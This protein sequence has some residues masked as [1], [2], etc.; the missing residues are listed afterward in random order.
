LLVL[1]QQFFDFSSESFDLARAAL[2]KKILTTSGDGS[3]RAESPAPRRG[4]DMVSYPALYQINTRVW[5][6][7]L[8]DS[9]GRPAT[10]A[11]I[12]DDF[13]DR[14]AF[15]GF[16]YIWFLGL[17]QT[18]A[19]GRQ[20]ALGRPDWRQAF[21]RILPDFTET[22]VTGSPFAVVAYT[23]NRDFGD[24]T[25][26]PDLRQRLLARGLK[27]MVD[28]VPNHTALD[29]PWVK[30][31]PEFYIQGSQADLAREPSNYR[32]VETQRGAV[33]LAHG[34]DPYFP[35][36]TDTFQLN[37]RHPALREVMA[38]ELLNLTDLADGVRC[39]MAMLLLPA[40][41]R[42]TWGSRSRPA[43]GVAPVDTSFWPEAISRVKAKNSRFSFMAE[44]YWGLESELLQQGFDYA[45]D[46]GLYDLLVSRDVARVRA[47]LEADQAYQ[48]K[49]VRFLENHDE[50]RAAQKF[51]GPV[52]QAA[53]VATYFLLG[54]RFFHE[55][56][57][58]GR[59]VHVPMQL[60]RR[61]PEAVDPVWQEFY[62]KLLT[63]LKRP[64]L[65]EGRWQ[66]R[67]VH[68]AQEGSFAPDRFLAY[69]WEGAAGQH[70]L[71]TVNYGSTRGRGYV[72]LSGAD[73]GE[74]RIQLQDLMSAAVSEED[75]PEVLSRGLYLDLPAWGFQ[76][77]V[78]TEL[79]PARA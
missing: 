12:P 53:A 44:V 3:V 54:L 48:E 16:D 59:R 56:Q 19:A 11:D 6:R 10:L 47:H 63:C 75:G 22:D 49:L 55:G 28:F 77:L 26:L 67:E 18:G 29:H 1:Y 31:H 42:R 65:R 24:D 71:V 40:I 25:T 66:L 76:V 58:E 9:L 32:Q 60:G 21:Q 68:P 13:L 69:W 79:P 20:M 34:R 4:I 5:L 8:A 33:I 15:L 50:A 46:K 72:D 35:G 74:N 36:W 57:L 78:L 61:P 23:L 52:H 38:Q 64:E 7:E 73:L 70:L 43:D 41:I 27:L 45:Y 30:I 2:V 37:Y 14:L 17:W 51:P 39:D 62:A